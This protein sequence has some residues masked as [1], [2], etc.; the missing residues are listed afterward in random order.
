MK[1]NVNVL[2]NDTRP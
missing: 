2:N 1:Q